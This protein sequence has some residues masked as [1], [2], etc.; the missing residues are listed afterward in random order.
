MNEQIK[1]YSDKLAYE[2]DLWDLK[3]ELE[4]EE[5]YVNV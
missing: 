1:H 2:T 4:A 3:V 5:H